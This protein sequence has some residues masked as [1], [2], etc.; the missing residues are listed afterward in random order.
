MA[1]HPIPIRRLACALLAGAALGPWSAPAP[2]AAPP[3]CDH[4][5]ALDQL[6]ID[7]GAARPGE[8]LCLAG[9]TRGVPLHITGLHGT[10]AQPIRIVNAPDQRVVFDTPGEPA[11]RIRDSSHLQLTGSHRSGSPAVPWG[12][13]VR[14]ARNKGIRIDG[15]SHDLELDYLEVSGVTFSGRSAAGIW[16]QGTGSGAPVAGIEIHHCYVHDVGS[17]GLYVGPSDYYAGAPAG[18]DV[19]LHHNRIE[20]SG[21]DGI[22][23]GG[24]TRG[25]RID[26]NTVRRDSRAD[27]P[28]QRAGINAN[29]GSDCR[30]EAN[31]VLGGNGPGIL[32]N[33]PRGGRIVNNVVAHAGREGIK[34]N[35]ND[36]EAPAAITIDHNSVVAPAGHGIAYYD[37]HGSP[38]TVRNNLLAAVGGSALAGTWRPNGTLGGNVTGALAVFRFRDPAADD[39]RLTAGAPAIDAGV[40]AGV[41]DDRDGVP[42][43]TAPDAGAHELL[44]DPPD[45]DGD[46]IADARDV[47]PDQPDPDQRDTDGDGIGNRCDPDF[48]NDGRVNFAD[49]AYF[50]ARSAEIHVD[51]DGDG[52]RDGRDLQ[53]LRQWFLRPPG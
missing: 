35:R 1:A 44:A 53:R 18:R 46:G 39:Y 31:R 10:A 30:I 38:W 13:A 47:C 32:L 24:I 4:T 37:D 12:I 15:A 45:R 33:D 23:V 41:P 27:E 3:A 36:F 14:H 11:I 7:A 49:L 9:G 40:A 34:V 5:I 48:N 8:T 42:R 6:A 21:W 2:A 51:L 52:Q 28:G 19:H 20:D 43:D 25:C 17:E 50:T 16:V 26:H 22:Q 29:P